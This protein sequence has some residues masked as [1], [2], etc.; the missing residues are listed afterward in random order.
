MFNFSSRIENTFKHPQQADA[1]DEDCRM[2]HVSKLELLKTKIT[3]T[4]Q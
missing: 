1:F 4:V 3:T 2:N